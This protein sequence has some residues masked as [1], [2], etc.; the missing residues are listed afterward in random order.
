LSLAFWHSHQYPICIPLLPIHATCPAHL[1]EYT[2]WNVTFVALHRN[3]LQKYISESQQYREGVT[4]RQNMASVI[5]CSL[6]TAFR[7]CSLCRYWHG[8]YIP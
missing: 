8:P 5:S 6:H 7:C 1:I 2:F 3:S 4:C